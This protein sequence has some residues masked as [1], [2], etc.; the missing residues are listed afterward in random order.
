VR[1]NR[2]KPSVRINAADGPPRPL[3]DR[4]SVRGELGPPRRLRTVLCTIAL[5]AGWQS[6]GVVVKDH[7]LSALFA[8]VYTF[9]GLLTCCGHAILPRILR[10]S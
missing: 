7:Y 10:L 9:A 3:S 2:T 1:W 5:W 4:E 8:D 6:V